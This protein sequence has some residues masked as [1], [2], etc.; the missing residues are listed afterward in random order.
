MTLIQQKNTPTTLNALL[1][2][3]LLQE[4]ADTMPMSKLLEKAR[5]GFEYFKVKEIHTYMQVPPT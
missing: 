4:R 1:S 5:M 3:L 2:A